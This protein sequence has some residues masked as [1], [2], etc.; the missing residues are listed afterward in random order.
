[1]VLQIPPRKRIERGE[2]LVEQ[3]HFRLRHQRAGDRHPLGLAAGQF[4]RLGSG[5]VGEADP[6]QRGRDLVAAHAGRQIGEAEPDIVGHTEPRQQPRLL[7]DDADFRVRRRD[8]EVIEGHG[9]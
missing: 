6:R 1:M 4:A 5:L 8:D 7:E 2:R 3:Q 9:A